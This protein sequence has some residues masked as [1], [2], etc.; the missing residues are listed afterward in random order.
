MKETEYKYVGSCAPIEDAW[1]KATGRV[2]YC[3]DRQSHDLMHMKLICS[4]VAHGRVKAID[5]AEAMKVEGVVKILTCFNTPSPPYDRGRIMSDT[6]AAEQ[7]HL[8]YEHVRFMGDRVGGV[9]ATTAEAALLASEK[10]KVVYE[11]LPAAFTVEDTLKAAPPIHEAHTVCECETLSY[12]EEGAKIAYKEVVTE[13]KLQRTTHMAMETHAAL[14]EYRPDTGK[15]TV[16]TPCQSVFGIRN[17]LCQVFRLPM[18]RVRVKKT[19]MGGSFGSKQETI[20]EPL[21]AAA[22]IAVGGRV[23]LNFNREEV[24][25]NTILRHSGTFR[26]AGGFARDGRIVSFRADCVL[27]AGAYQTVS[28]DYMAECME[29]L[30]KV[31]D[32]RDIEITG[33]SVCTNTP[34]NGSYRSW[35]SAESAFAMEVH[36]DHAARALLIDPL[37][38]RM[39]NVHKP[40]G[41]NRLNGQALGNVRFLECLSKGAALF[42]WEE[43]KKK[44]QQSRQGRYHRGVGLAVASHTS[45]AYGGRSDLV[46]L[47][48]KMQEDGSVI[49]NLCFHDHGCGTAVALKHIAAEVLK[50]D[51]SL[52]SMSEGDTDKDLHDYGCY[53]SRT[54]YVAG[55]A[56]ELAAGKM[57]EKLAQVGAILL[58]TSAKRI[59]LADG[60]VF[61]RE[62]PERRVSYGDCAMY[63]LRHMEQSM[64]VMYDHA[65]SAN[66]GVPAVHFAEVVVDTLTGLVQ[67]EKYVA[68]HDIGR[69]I[70]PAMCRA[71]VEGAVQN[72]IGMALMEEVKVNEHTGA[73]ITTG[74]KKYNWINAYDMPEVEVAFVE[75]GEEGGPF[76][77]KSIGESALA[78][79]MPTIVNAVNDAL[80][81]QLYELPLNPE[82]ILWALGRKRA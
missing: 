40:G 43:R 36:M 2:E 57:C 20:L 59:E 56:V 29:K 82:R 77:A 31:Y 61:L 70:N 28:P 30:G 78:P 32:I 1:G 51:E 52:I 55:R 41:K 72:G 73:L 19:T 63:A 69:A 38:L 64:T 7:E 68:V 22:A 66:P 42:E 50:M 39:R 46:S 54:I 65:S 26:M 3:A 8:F 27:D 79:V 71:Q 37:A 14:A 35:G 9:I 48:M 11:E 13:A 74:L 62:H 25:R 67:V 18:N 80:E 15:L 49:I 4:T 10:V 23:L 47:I 17:T 60:F 5:T 12:H 21:A 34:V 16:H 58:K 33:K 75:M 44:A 81:T 6:W 53:A 24:I 45:G 76:G